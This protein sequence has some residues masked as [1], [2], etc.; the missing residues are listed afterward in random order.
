MPNLRASVR[1]SLLPPIQRGEVPVVTGFYGVDNEGHATL[2]GRGGSDYVA[3]ILA[4]ALDASVIELWKDVPGFLAADPRMV[5]D[6]RVLHQ[7]GYAE[8]AELAQFG[9]K[10]LH[11]R[12]VEPAQARHIPIVVRGVHD[13][14]AAG[15]T[16]S[17][18]AG[19]GLASVACRAGVAV[20]RLRGPSL[21]ALPGVA[22]AV[23]GALRPGPINVLAVANTQTVLS[24]AIEER[25]VPRTRDALTMLPSPA[26]RSME[27]LGG[28]S[29]L[30]VVGSALSQPGAAARVLAAVADAN[31]DVEMVSL[32]SNEMAFDFVVPSHQAADAVRAVHAVLHKFGT[33]T[34]QSSGRRPA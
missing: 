10:V 17:V 21:A 16:V 8:A 23:F 19:T 3:G 2:F 12:A 31:V 15:T 27:V 18:P 4:D 22:H 25:D 29:L 13:P 20:I 1:A 32:P 24:L 34:V 26:L 30:C 28:R 14:D 7:L 33:A 6:A 5:P 9:A 11:P